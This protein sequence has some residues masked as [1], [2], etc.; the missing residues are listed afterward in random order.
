[1]DIDEKESV[2]EDNAKILKVLSECTDDYIFMFD[3]ESDNY[4][5][6]DSIVKE[7]D[8]PSNIFSLCLPDELSS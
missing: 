6:S 2:I 5:A 8:L 7:F 1:M 3:L 4:R